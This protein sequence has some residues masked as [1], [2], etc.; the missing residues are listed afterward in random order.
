VK[1][2]HLA[3]ALAINLFWGGNF[4]AVKVGVTHFEPF[5]FSALRFGLLA[6]LML[7]WLRLQPGQ[8]KR[9]LV[10]A[11]TM[12]VV[13]FALFFTGM[14]LAGDVS[15][16]AIV[17]QLYVPFATLLAVL[18]LGE[19]IAW[20]RSLAIAVAFAGVLV[21]G[22]DARAF[23]YADALMIISVGAFVFAVGQVQMRGL[24][25]V[26]VFA[27]QGWINLVAAPIMLALSLLLEEGQMAALGTAEL[28]VVSALLYST[29]LGSLAGHGGAY[30]LIARYPVSTVAP[31][32][33]LTPIIGV[34][35]GVTLLGDV[36]TLQI[37]VGGALVIG[38]VAVITIRSARKGAEPVAEAV[39]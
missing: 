19:R 6:M 25:N 33:L 29:V 11:L 21:I 12:G 34:F 9:I 5:L 26:S 35:A 4:V 8:M 3:L 16:V 28:P 20:R 23:Q 14:R 36:V 27:L 17:V 22:F 32:F 31:M 15:S 2:Q 38:G 13:H 18:F 1:P 30:F 10:V 24:R 37:A 7:P 39:P